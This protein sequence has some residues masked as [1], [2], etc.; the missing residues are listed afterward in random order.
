MA[1]AERRGA[2]YSFGRFAK[3]QEFSDSVAFA[4]KP[5]RFIC[6]LNGETGEVKE[7]IMH[8]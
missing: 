8:I 1:F 4:R 3:N 7:R 6:N 5:S 2:S